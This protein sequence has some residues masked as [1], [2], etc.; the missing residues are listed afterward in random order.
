MKLHGGSLMV[1]ANRTIS[2]VIQDDSR[3]DTTYQSATE[4]VTRPEFK[5]PTEKAHVPRFH[6]S[7]KAVAHEEKGSTIS[8]DVYQS[9]ILGISVHN[10]LVFHG[11]SKYM[12]YMT[13]VVKL[14]SVVKAVLIT[15]QPRESQ[16][17]GDLKDPLVT[18]RSNYL[19]G[20]TD[21][22]WYLEELVG[23]WAPT[24]LW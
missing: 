10:Q 9:T 1:I 18:L 24:T 21:L 13:S 17:N 16:A 12:K 22:F 23:S 19:G 4:S 3:P 7:R 20:S 11:F 5:I 6:P 2:Q 15:A 8:V 14:T